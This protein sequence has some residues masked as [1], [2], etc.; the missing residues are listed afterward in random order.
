MSTAALRTEPGAPALPPDAADVDVTVVT[1]MAGFQSLAGEWRDLFRRAA[2]PHNVFQDFAFLDAWASHYLERPAALHVVAA[3]VGG[4]L[5]CVLPLT[6]RRRFG[7]NVLEFMGAPVAQFDDALVAPDLPARAVAVV[8]ETVAESGADVI[9]ARRVRADAALWRL[10]PPSPVQIEPAQAPFARLACRVGPDGPGKAYSA[11]DRSSHRRRLRRIGELG[12]FTA[13]EARP[14]AE[15]AALAARAVDLKTAS[16][17]GHGL[18]APT[19]RDTRFRDFFTDI[20]GRPDSGLRASWFALDGQVIAVDLSFDCKG[21]TFGHVL[22]AHP[23]F[24]REGLG[25]LLI[26]HAFANAGKR[27]SAFFELMAPLDAYKLRHADGC[28]DVGMLVVP[29]SARGRLL[30]QAIFGHALPAAR[31][32]ARRLPA[33]LVRWLM[34]R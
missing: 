34:K 23:D 2:L 19:V 18:A 8:W 6:R 4:R 27:G 21:S 13:G 32:V 28:V 29:L 33:G 24:G 15:A 30:G 17:D 7:L 5:D 3:R 11:R 10:R 9:L 1:D 16:L 22:S 25:Q 31:R 14:G 12:D 26:H 20:A